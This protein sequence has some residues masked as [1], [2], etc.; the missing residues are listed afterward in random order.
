MPRRK[1]KRP[2]GSRGMRQQQQHPPCLQDSVSSPACDLMVLLP[3]ESSGLQSQLMVKELM[4]RLASSGFTHMALTHTIYGRPRPEDRADKALPESLWKVS[5]D[6]GTEKEPASKK[7]KFNCGGDDDAKSSN[8]PIRILRRLHAVIENL[9]DVGV[10]MA[11]GPHADI[12]NEYDIVSVSPRNEKVFASVCK[13]ASVADIITLDYTAGRG[14]LKLPY[15]IRSVDIKNVV[16]R[17]AVLEVPFAPALLHTKQRKA[18]VQTSRELQMASMGVKI[19]VLFSSG[20][21]TFDEVDMG[22]MALRTPGDLTNLMQ[23]VLRFDPKTSHDA[24]GASG[25]TVIKR[26][27]HRRFGSSDIADVFVQDN[28]IETVESRQPDSTQLTKGT[29]VSVENKEDDDD[30]DSSHDGIED[31]YIAM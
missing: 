27:K 28:T 8:S 15:K 31:G 24:V 1:S 4:N 12:L 10:Y 2:R 22:A 20:D 30:D 29:P 13:S 18:L 16:A 3:K 21:R 25:M 14:G 9:S 7:R 5:Q 11:N 23:A 6:K 17:Q 26:A 19:N